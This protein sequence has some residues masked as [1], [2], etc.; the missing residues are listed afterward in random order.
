MKFPA[1]EVVAAR[2]AAL[3]AEAAAERLARRAREATAPRRWSLLGW[4]PGNG[5][6]AH[7]GR[8]RLVIAR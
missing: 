7:S 5:G 1:H 4:T 3:E 8:H 2:M 6:G